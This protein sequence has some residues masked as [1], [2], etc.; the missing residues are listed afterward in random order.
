MENQMNSITKL[1]IKSK[2]MSTMHM[3][4]FVPHV[5]KFTNSESSD[6]PHSHSFSCRTK[7]VTQLEHE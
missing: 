4:Y 5:K 6:F 3:K 1:T 7:Y 2:N